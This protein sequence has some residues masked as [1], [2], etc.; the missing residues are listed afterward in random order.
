M[1]YPFAAL[2]PPVHPV[3]SGS[4]RPSLGPVHSSIF[5]LSTLHRQSFSA[6][7]CLILLIV[8][9]RS[10]WHSAFAAITIPRDSVGTLRRYNSCS[11]KKRV[12]REY[13]TNHSRDQSSA[14]I[15]CC[16]AL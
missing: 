7:V 11:V 4:L 2:Q 13:D 10:G 6:Y 15:I 14:A 9:W 16:P 12:H 5:L 3:A 8:P 1:M